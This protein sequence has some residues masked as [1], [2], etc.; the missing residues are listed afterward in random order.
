MEHM[1]ELCTI[2][3]FTYLAHDE[4][5][6]GVAGGHKAVRVKHQPLISASLLGLQVGVRG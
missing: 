4:E 3:R 1:P 5:V 6:G 2:E